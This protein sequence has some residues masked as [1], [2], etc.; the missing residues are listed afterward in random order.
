MQNS[1]VLRR[2]RKRRELVQPY[3]L[4]SLSGGT[5]S[6]L[7][8]ALSL[9][10]NTLS[11]SYF[12]L[13][14][15]FFIFLVTYIFTRI[16]VGIVSFSTYRN[17]LAPSSFLLLAWALYIY[18]TA[19][20]LTGIF[21]V[22]VLIGFSLS[23][24]IVSIN[25]KISEDFSS[26]SIRA[27]RRNALALGTLSAPVALFVSYFFGNNYSEL[28][29]V[30]E[31]IALFFGALFLFV[32]IFRFYVRKIRPQQD[33]IL[34]TVNKTLA[35]LRMLGK[36]RGKAFFLATTLIDILFIFAAWSI[37][38]YLPYYSYSLID[39]AKSSFLI[40]AGI[41]LAYVVFRFAGQRLHFK[42]FFISSYFV[43]SVVF[44]V[45]FLILS[46][47]KSVLDLFLALLI[48]SSV[49]LFEEGAK[50]Y[51]LSGFDA[52]DQQIVRRS[53]QL[54]VLPFIVLAPLFS[55][56]FFSISFS[57]GFASAIIPAAISLLLTT[58]LISNPKITRQ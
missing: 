25:S 58:F 32:E 26:T 40:F 36:I 19:L 6:I 22:A 56:E 38:I 21:L 17:L 47:A 43:R 18:S 41:S 10:I 4:S 29:T 14:I 49:G 9:K 2:P 8:V 33:P 7:Y 15:V 3:L 57:L 55:Y 53:S 16:P 52:G 24:A 45:A 37:L 46:L 30:I 51:V 20:T 42:M 28:I 11:I 13:G 23:A 54:L 50:N 48:L 35:P 5:T 27:N 39:S 31:Y 44:I 1:R 34:V 12:S